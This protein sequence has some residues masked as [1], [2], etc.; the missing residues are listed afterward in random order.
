MEKKKGETTGGMW[1]FG[2]EQLRVGS[3]SSSDDVTAPAVSTSRYCTAGKRQ[4]HKAVKTCISPEEVNTDDNNF[5]H[6]LESLSLC[7]VATRVASL[8]Q[9]LCGLQSVKLVSVRCVESLLTTAHFNTR[10]APAVKI[11]G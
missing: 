8:Q 9:P 7:D 4:L 3:V 6:L 11:H 5:T 10:S 1:R 2:D